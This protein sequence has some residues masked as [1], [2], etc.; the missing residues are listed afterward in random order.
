MS[1]P[2][3]GITCDLGKREFPEK[4]KERDRHI[5]MDAYIEAVLKAGALP[6]LLPSVAE[7]QDAV[8]FL[9]GID[10]LVISGGGHDIDPDSY[11]EKRLPACGP[12]NA[13]RGLT[14]LAL[15]R[16]AM[17]RDMPVLGICGGMQVISVAGG[18]TLYQDI[19]SQVKGALAHRPPNPKKATYTYHEV[20]IL[21]SILG[22]TVGEGPITVNSHHHQSVKEL[23]EGMRLTARS[24]DG[25]VEAIECASCRFVVGVQWHPESMASYG[26]GDSLTAEHLFARLAGEAREYVM[27]AGDRSHELA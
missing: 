24:P 18:G 20:D 19:A 16:S 15:C 9:D 13:K 5:L 22:E 25:V 12:P 2:R 14:E 23:G 4:P 26:L 3:I 21:P 27:Y 8:A 7:E 6:F 11:G 17:S 1:R 10:A